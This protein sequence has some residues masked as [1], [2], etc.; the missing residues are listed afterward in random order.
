[1]TDK[2]CEKLIS[3]IYILLPT[4]EGRSHITKEIIYEPEEAYINFQKNLNKLRIE[5]SGCKSN[6]K[7]IVE[8]EEM[9]N[10]IEGLKSI[11]INDHDLLK[12]HVFNLIDICKKIQS[13]YKD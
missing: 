8:F 2:Y 10:I 11:T 9:Y 13:N 4:I 12:S 5:I 1:M 3:K 6:Y 7:D